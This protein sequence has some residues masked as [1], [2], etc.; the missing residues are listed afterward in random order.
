MPMPDERDDASTP[1]DPVPLEVPLE[2]QLKNLPAIEY[3]GN[4]NR[5][6]EDW[7]AERRRHRL[8]IEVFGAAL[9]LIAGG[10]GL[11]VTHRPAFLVIGVFAALA[12]GAYEFLVNSFE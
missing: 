12:V 7:T 1:P 3:P 10:A 5:A 2:D 8:R 4:D 11:A 9:L 6:F